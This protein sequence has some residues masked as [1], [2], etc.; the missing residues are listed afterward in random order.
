M[1]VLGWHL[2]LYV[3]VLYTQHYNAL[4]RTFKEHI[5]L[6]MGTYGYGWVRKKSVTL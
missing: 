5:G 3:Y 2:N 1:K 4:A 6:R